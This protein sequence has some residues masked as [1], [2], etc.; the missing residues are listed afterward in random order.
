ME[1][2]MARQGIKTRQPIITEE[3]AQ[4]M[5]ANIKGQSPTQASQV[6]AQM[7]WYEEHW[8]K[9]EPVP[10]SRINEMDVDEL[11]RVKKKAEDL[12]GSSTSESH[13]NFYGK[14]EGRIKEKIKEKLAKK[15]EE[16]GKQMEELGGSSGGGLF[17]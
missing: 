12:K 2:D 17:G 14:E 16:L 6:K 1:H 11:Q 13:K 9:G 5:V 3:Q 7:T 4:V 10:D 8:I 15:R